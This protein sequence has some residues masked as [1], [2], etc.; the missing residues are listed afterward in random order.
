MAAK[1]VKKKSSKA[2]KVSKKEPIEEGV[3]KKIVKKENKQ[4][5]WFLVLA[6]VVFASFLIPYFYIESLKSFDFAGIPWKIEALGEQKIYHG[7][8]YALSGADL[9][10]NIYLRIDP[11]ENDVFASGTFNLFRYG[12]YISL[13]PEVNKCRGEVSRVMVDLGS[14]LKAGVGI[15]NLAVATNNPDYSNETGLPYIDC[16]NLHERTII[17]IEKGEERSVV[18]SNENPDCYIIT[19]NDCNDGAPIEKFMLESISAF[20]ENSSEEIKWKTN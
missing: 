14:F 16:S 17:I 4:V 2:K 8:F 7:R 5:T 10:Y 19:V 6:G 18:Q 3:G 11:R 15:A 9:I 13:S 20:K 1:K 12:A